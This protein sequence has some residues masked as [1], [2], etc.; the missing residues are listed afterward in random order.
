MAKVDG[1]DLTPAHWEV[2]HFMCEY[3]EEYQTSPLVRMLVNRAIAK[4]D[5]LNKRETYLTA[6]KNRFL[7]RLRLFLWAEFPTYEQYLR[8]GW[9]QMIKYAGLYRPSGHV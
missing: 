4:K 7:R 6:G 2:I 3:Y 8:D 5:Y 9:R 1:L